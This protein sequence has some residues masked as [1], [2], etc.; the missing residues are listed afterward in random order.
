MYFITVAR[1]AVLHFSSDSF[2]ECLIVG[3]CQVGKASLVSSFLRES[4]C[5][6]YRPTMYLLRCC[7]VVSIGHQS[8]TLRVRD[9]LVLHENIRRHLTLAQ[10]AWPASW[11]TRNWNVGLCCWEQIRFGTSTKTH[12][13]LEAVHWQKSNSNLRR[14]GQDGI[15]YR[16]IASSSDLETVQASSRGSSRWKNASE[17]MI[18]DCSDYTRDILDD[19]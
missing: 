2:L 9:I 7:K 6:E 4:F 14:G 16:G 19:G 5:D 18:V 11:N 3:D 17:E 1:Q 10:C 12:F 8:L 13:I 15:E